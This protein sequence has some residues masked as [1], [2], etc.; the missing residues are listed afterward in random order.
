[1]RD[2]RDGSEV[3]RTLDDLQKVVADGGNVM[4]AVIAASKA[5]A[6]QGEIVKR[7]ITEVGEYVA[8]PI[9]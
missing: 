7:V 1:V 2:K 6:S 3:D 8:P 5:H 9:F 4:T